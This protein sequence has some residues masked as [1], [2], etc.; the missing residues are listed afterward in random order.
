MAIIQHRITTISKTT[1]K[2]WL[3]LDEHTHTPTSW[4]SSSNKIRSHT[5][6]NIQYQIS[7]RETRVCVELREEEL[8]LESELPSQ[9]ACA[10]KN[11]DSAVTLASL[12]SSQGL[13]LIVI[14]L[15]DFF[16]LFCEKYFINDFNYC[17]LLSPDRHP[18]TE[19][20]HHTDGICEHR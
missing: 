4:V 13:K 15:N 7:P 17:H 3:M 6:A 8:Q 2:E 14:H 20:M 5:L 11:I 19:N 1:T 9:G 18:S 10:R 12:E 16:F